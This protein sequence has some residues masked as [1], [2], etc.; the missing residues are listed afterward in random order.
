M[1]RT[2]LLSGDAAARGLNHGSAHAADIR[3]YVDERVGLVAG[4]A[5]S[6]TPLSVDEI[7]SLADSML[8][9]HERYSP[10][11]HEEM[12]AMAAGAAISPAEAVVV[13]GF[14]DFIDTVRGVYG[15]GPVEDTCTAVIVPGPAAADGRPLLGQTWDMHDTATP[16]IV[17]L[18]VRP[19]TGP[20][21]LVFTTVGCLGQIGMN[22]AGVA[23]G[24][25]NLTA[26]VG[27][28]GV[29]WPTVVRKALQQTSL[30]DAVTA[31]LDAELAGAHNF[32]LVDR[33]GRGVN[34]E[35][36]P[37][38]RVVTEVD[39]SAFVHTNHTL[40]PESSAHEAERPGSL[41]ESSHARLARASALVADG[42][43]DP[44][45]LMALTRDPNAICQVSVEP[46]HVESCGGAVMSPETG[47][48]WAVWG[49]PDENEYE[50]FTIGAAV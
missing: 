28:R 14:T 24:I 7:L 48:M 46:Y 23:I 50:R 35:A 49:R 9:A 1:I 4:G 20:G 43:L 36:M 47:E 26:A 18:D 27:V 5:W 16:H 39:R 10:D 42:G 21:A 44:T 32:L 41:M 34:I 22:E 3:E 17:M 29:T 30:Q 19:S 13:G 33:S 38:V 25:N 2:T 37:Q 12:M 8:D 40:A 11:L 15:N 45:A 31:V 6:G